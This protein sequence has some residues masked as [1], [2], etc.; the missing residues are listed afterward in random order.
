MNNKGTNDI[1][2]AGL[3]LCTYILKSQNP[4]QLIYMMIS[5]QYNDER[6]MFILNTEAINK[7]LLVLDLE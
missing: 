2:K 1:D 3:L 4:Q 5:L 6:K 7:K